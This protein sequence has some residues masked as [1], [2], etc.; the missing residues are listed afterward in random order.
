M[1]FISTILELRIYDKIIGG[2]TDT[3]SWVS[4]VQWEY[5]FGCRDVKTSKQLY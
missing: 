4:L 1:W 2:T 3:I 5:I